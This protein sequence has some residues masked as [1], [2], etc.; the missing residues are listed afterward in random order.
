MYVRTYVYMNDERMYSMYVCLYASIEPVTE[1]FQQDWNQ[2]D[3]I[4]LEKKTCMYV[5]MYVSNY[6]QYLRFYYLLLRYEFLTQ[7]FRQALDSE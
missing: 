7:S 6:Y 1:T 2:A 4:R 5:C 3:Y